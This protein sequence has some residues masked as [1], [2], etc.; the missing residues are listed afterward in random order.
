MRPAAR[1]QHQGV[2][3]YSIKEPVQPLESS[4][5][6]PPGPEKNAGPLPKDLVTQIEERAGDTR[7]YVYVTDKNWGV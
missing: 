7:A 2:R 4:W 3:V 1:L 6:V 5:F